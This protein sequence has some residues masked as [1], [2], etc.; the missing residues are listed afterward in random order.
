MRLC[1]RFIAKKHFKNEK[2][3]LENGNIEK[4]IFRVHSAN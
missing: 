1:H 4:L 2:K 3:I